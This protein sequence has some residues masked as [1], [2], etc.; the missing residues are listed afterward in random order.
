M[1]YYVYMHWSVSLILVKLVRVYESSLPKYQEFTYSRVWQPCSNTTTSRCIYGHKLEW[2]V[3]AIHQIQNNKLNIL[4]VQFFLLYKLEYQNA[5]YTGYY[6]KVTELKNNFNK[7]DIKPQHNDCVSLKYLEI[8]Y[9]Y[10]LQ[11]C[12]YQRNSLL[13]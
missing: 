2:K 6:W 7:F 5:S 4:P 1:L 3:E 12:N 13:E 10:N 8:R 9:M 11:N